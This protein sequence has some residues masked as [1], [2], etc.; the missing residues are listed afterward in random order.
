MSRST[1]EG[2]VSTSAPLKPAV[3]QQRQPR[4]QHPRKPAS[5]PTAG[6]SVLPS[7]GSQ[8]SSERWLLLPSGKDGGSPPTTAR[9][10]LPL[11]SAFRRCSPYRAAGAGGRCCDRKRDQLGAADHAGGPP[12]KSAGSKCRIAPVTAAA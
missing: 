1:A 4:S 2:L 8:Q 7:W 11:L 6:V 9:G 3:R 10:S 12:Q 5:G